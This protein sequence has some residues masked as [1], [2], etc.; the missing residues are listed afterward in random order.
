M[1][2]VSASARASI[3][4][5]ASTSRWR[6][7]SRRS[8][9]AGFASTYWLQIALWDLHRLTDAAPARLA[10]F[11]VDPVLPVPGPAGRQ[12]ADCGTIS[13]WGLAGISLATAMV[14]TGLAVAIKGLEIRLEAGYGDAARAFCDRPDQ[15]A[16]ADVRAAS[17]SPRSQPA[18]ARVAQALD[19]ASPPPTLL[20]AADRSLLLPRRDRRRTGRAARSW[21]RRSRSPSRMPRGSPGRHC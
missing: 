3:G 1:A 12:R 6:R 20:Q 10:V 14:F 17:S 5:Q 16:I 13:A 2:T 4:W 15:R 19:A 21:A 18:A 11:A 7:S 8:R 9:S